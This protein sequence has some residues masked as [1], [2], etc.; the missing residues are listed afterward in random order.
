[1]GTAFICFGKRLRESPL[2]FDPQLWQALHLERVTVG[3]WRGC[4][5]MSGESSRVLQMPL[6]PIRDN[7]YLITGQTADILDNLESRQGKQNG[8]ESN[9]VWKSLILSR[10][11]RTCACR[12]LNIVS[13]EWAC[14][15]LRRRR[16]Q[17]L[18]CLQQREQ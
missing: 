1:M 10:S 3:G 16:C 13:S 15:K 4:S 17:K 12:D 5:S 8:N 6:L 9:S 14:R 18:N 11:A 7:R 2:T